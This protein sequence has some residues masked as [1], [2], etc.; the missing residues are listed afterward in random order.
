MRVSECDGR[1]GAGGDMLEFYIGGYAQGKLN[2][3]LRE[4][5]QPCRVVEGEAFAPKSWEECL[6]GETLVVNHFHLWVRALLRQG[7]SPEELLE[8]FLA[9]CP[10]CVIISD[11]VGC[12]I[13]PMEREERVYRERLGR[14]LTMVAERA[15]RVERVI[16]GLGQRIK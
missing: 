15:E 16:C 12:G 3:V 10:D 11:E 7:Q 14:I 9:H 1:K 5:Q 4:K 13:V 2:Y 8:D 6:E